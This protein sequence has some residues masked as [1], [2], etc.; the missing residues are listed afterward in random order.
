MSATIGIPFIGTIDAS[1][2]AFLQTIPAETFVWGSAD[3]EISGTMSLA[4]FRGAFDLS[5][6]ATDASAE[7]TL[8]MSESGAQ[9]FKDALTGL[10]T[11]GAKYSAGTDP[12]A[13]SKPLS[14]GSSSLQAYLEA[15]AQK[16]IDEDLANNN[17]PAEVEGEHVFNLALNGFAADASAAVAELWT[18]MD[19][20][21]NQAN[22]NL[23]AR[24]FSASR[25]FEVDAS[26]AF[27]AVLPAKVN[28]VIVFRFIVTQQYTIHENDAG[29]A[30][31][32]APNGG[33]L[34]AA[35][36][37]TSPGV[38]LAIRYGVGDRSVNLVVTLTA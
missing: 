25:Y 5:E 3:V 2:D 31:A 28:D 19:S 10:L 29:V 17:I 6:N 38:G 24:Q 11:G 12:S 37:P 32:T 30:G 23:I 16:Q 8:L 22:L 14:V 18:D 20:S 4:T 1:G 15:W 33:T 36:A 7:L 21:A 13:Y 35:P 9:S 26:E 27:T 34:N